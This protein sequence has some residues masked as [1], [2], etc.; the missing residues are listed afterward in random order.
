MALE[1]V[2]WEFGS[3]LLD[4]AG[5]LVGLGAGD[6]R[7]LGRATSVKE[8]RSRAQNS[9]H[10]GNLK[11]AWCGPRSRSVGLNGPCAVKEN[12]DELKPD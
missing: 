6:E 1:R 10:V 5:W 2:K 9:V 7:E 8:K 11:A 12:D 4:G 3:G